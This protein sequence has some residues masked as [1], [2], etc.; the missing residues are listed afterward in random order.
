MHLPRCRGSQVLLSIDPM[1][2]ALILF[3]LM[4]AILGASVHSVEAAHAMTGGDINAAHAVHS[5][6][7]DDAHDD[8]GQDNQGDDGAMHH[9]CPSAWV[10]DAA[11]PV[12]TVDC[13]AAPLIAAGYTAL[14]SRANDPLLEPP[15]A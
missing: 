4:F 11:I 12:E 2:R 8:A 6:D 10:G 13:A 1:Q 15:S 9:H 5:H 14:S 7:A 3:A